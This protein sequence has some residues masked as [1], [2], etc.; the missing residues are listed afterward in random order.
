MR[1]TSVI[2]G[3]HS[4]KA[5]SLKPCNK[6]HDYCFITNECDKPY[7]ENSALY[8]IL[9]TKNNEESK[10]QDLNKAKLKMPRETKDDLGSYK[11]FSHKDVSENTI[12]C[13]NKTEK[14]KE[15]EKMA[16]IQAP[17]LIGEGCI[18]RMVESTVTLEDSAIKIKEI[19]ALVENLNTTVI[20]DKVIIQGTLHKQ[21]FYVGEDAVV[22]HQTELIPISFFIDI[23]NAMPGMS[24]TVIPVIEHVTYTLLDSETLHQKVILIFSVTVTDIQNLDVVEGTGTPLYFVSRIMGEGS[25][26]LIVETAVTLVQPT[27]KVDEITAT[28]QNIVTDVIDDKVIIQGILHKQVFYVGLDNIEYHQAEDIPFSLFVDVEGATPGMNVQVIPT[29]ETINYN[30]E[31]NSDLAQHVVIQFSV[32]VTEGVSVNLEE[33]AGPTI[34][35]NEIV[36]EATNQTLL[37]DIIAMENPTQK[38]RN[39]EAEITEINAQVI[40]NKVIL[41]GQIHK[42]IYYIGIDN[43]EYEQGEDIEFSFFVDLPNAVPGMNTTLNPT[44]ESVITELLNENEMLEKV[45]LS[46][47]V[48]VSS[49][50]NFDV[51]LVED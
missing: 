38:I 32:I 45:V 12:S 24:T 26:Q 39:V 35:L 6:R 44:I 15:E 46:V 47:D 3:V 41:Q 2:G 23:E 17:V 43:I 42:Q 20:Q 4:P 51:N 14:K 8:N 28:I 50:V 40:T 36:G 22:H 9:C 18:Q 25:Q 16:L 13:G 7:I 34:L 11:S 37:Q 49:T 30:L 5:Q 29:I 10:I 1:K 33:G 48:L 21:I 19:R 27:L 31:N